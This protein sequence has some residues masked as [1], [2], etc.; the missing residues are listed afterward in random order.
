MATIKKALTLKH[1]TR[2]IR[3]RLWGDQVVA[4]DNFGAKLTFFDPID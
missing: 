3:V 4:M 2:E 1:R